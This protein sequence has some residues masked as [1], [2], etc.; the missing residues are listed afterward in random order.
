MTDSLKTE[1]RLA[2]AGIMLV[3]YFGIK[4]DRLAKLAKDES[5]GLQDFVADDNT[6][7]RATSVAIVH[8][9]PEN[10]WPI[11]DVKILYLRIQ[12]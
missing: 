4:G 3:R 11:I 2:A 1:R 7:N 9:D 6:H 8:C 5:R 12:A 10:F